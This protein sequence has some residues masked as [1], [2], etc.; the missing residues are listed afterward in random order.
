MEHRLQVV[1][2]RVPML[3]DVRGHRVIEVMD[4]RSQVI[5]DLI[6]SNDHLRQQ[7]QLEHGNRIVSDGMDGSQQQLSDQQQHNQQ[8]DDHNDGQHSD[9]RP[10]D[11]HQEQTNHHN[12]NESNH[13]HLDN[14]NCPCFY[15]PHNPHSN[16][17]LQMSPSQ[18]SNNSPFA[19][20]HVGV[21]VPH[22][23]VQMQLTSS[24]LTQ[25]SLSQS[26]NHLQQSN[27][28]QQQLD[29]QQQQSTN[30]QQQQL[31][32][33]EEMRMESKYSSLINHPNSHHHL[34][35]HHHQLSALHHHSVLPPPPPPPHFAQLHSH[36]HGT[37][38]L[39]NGESLSDFVN[40]VAPNDGNGCN[41]I[42]SEFRH[43]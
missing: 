41:I 11:G 17:N 9:G 6:R 23:V 4:H 25:S 27:Q 33:E 26:P 40:L 28:Q 35:N 31:T 15:N 30:A 21:H 22:H 36:H 43:D 20:T 24:Q 8:N 2:H 7:Q 14:D 16:P 34:I 18:S 5:H 29:N 39:E 32:I 19:P 13:H 37:N 3:E 42:W 1:E 38:S 12:H 10:D